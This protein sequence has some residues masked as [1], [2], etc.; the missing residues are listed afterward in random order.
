MTASKRNRSR[1]VTVSTFLVFAVVAV[2]VARLVDVQVIR[3]STLTTDALGKR[4]IGETVSGDRGEILDADG[5][6]LAGTVLR[7]DITAVPRFAAGATTT[8][9]HG[10]TTTTSR[11]ELVGKIAEAT[12]GDAATMMTALTLDPTANY[13]VLV[14]GVGVD[15]LNAVNA[16]KISWVYPVRNSGRTYPRG[17]VAGNLVGFVG[18]DG[19]QAGLEYA[20]DSCL[21]GTDGTET[22]ER[23]ADG[24]KLPGSTVV[25]KKAVA[26]GTLM[27]TIDSD[28]QYLVQQSLATHAKELGAASATAVVVK[29]ADGTLKAVADYPSVDP[30]DVDGTDAN[31]LGSKAFTDLYEPGSTFKAMTAASLLDAGVATT[32]SRATVPDHR[33][34]PWGGVI[35][36][37]ESHPVENLTLAGVLAN[38]SNVG[39]SLLGEKL[40]PKQ[41]YEY[42]LK[43][44]LGST[45]DAK[46]PGEPTQAL[47]PSSEWDH[48]TDYNSMFGQGVSATAIQTAGIYQTLANG[49]VRVP[50][51]L[52]SGCRLPDGTVVDAPTTT[53]TRVVSRKAADDVVDMLE[54]TIPEG[55]LRGMTPIS[56]YN[57]AAKTGTAQVAKAGGGGYGSDFIISVAGIAPAE[58]PQYVVLVTFTKP[59]TKKTSFA[60]SPA[61][62]EI[63]SEVLETYRV[64]PS[65]TP[66]TDLPDTW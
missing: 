28:L 29:V 19:A 42:M 16:L 54:N 48:Q 55:T 38:S 21:A 23:G 43:F 39:I 58:K 64:R 61:F 27:T 7:Y 10:V 50:L 35:G 37:A 63:I 8:D 31:H 40:T 26:G 24:V 22:Y 6:V 4:S 33:Y 53:G 44:G 3:A 25:S 60:A 20:Y 11:S 12:G 52:V 66:R 62:R 34:F 56:G 49:G 36:D 45:T 15:A 46:F 41:R 57:V 59:T 9:S 13:A 65:T 14:K 2:F 1:R 47:R 18:T 17:A 5:T 30:N 51:S 32:A